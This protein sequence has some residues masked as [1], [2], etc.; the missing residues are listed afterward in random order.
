MQ[1]M[2]IQ[3]VCRDGFALKMTKQ[4]AKPKQGERTEIPPGYPRL[5]H[6]QGNKRCLLTLSPL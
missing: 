6:K 3:S 2:E 4:H 1:Q 5:G